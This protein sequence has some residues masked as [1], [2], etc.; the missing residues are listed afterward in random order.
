MRS[1]EIVREVEIERPVEEVFAFVADPTGDPRWCPKVKSVSP[2]GGGGDGGPGRGACYAVVHKPVPLRPE[3]RMEMTCVGWDPPRLLEWREE[4][5]TDVFLVS[6]EL[7]PLDG[8]RRTRFTQRSNAE[9]GAPRLLHPL[10]R[11]GI[12][13]DV[14]GQ[15]KRL[16]RLLEEERDY[17][18]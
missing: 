1:V 4:D 3:R 11:H 18:R 15:L 7:E 2:V 17:Q 12:G 8:G 13:R 5:C 9:I 14:A 10:F 6:Y 16:K